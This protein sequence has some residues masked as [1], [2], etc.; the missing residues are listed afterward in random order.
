MSDV[1][2]SIESAYVLY[3]ENHKKVLTAFLLLFFL[4]LIV[5]ALSP[6]PLLSTASLF[7]SLGVECTPSYGDTMSSFES[8]LTCALMQHLPADALV[9]WVMALVTTIVVLCVIKPLEEIISKKKISAWRTHLK[10][11]Q[12]NTIRLV[13]LQTALTAVNIIPAIVLSAFII[14]D[15]AHT[16]HIID[17]G[18]NL[19]Q[20]ASAFLSTYARI[21][22]T[23]ALSILLGFVLLLINI[24]LALS[25]TFVRVELVLT[26]KGL[27]D[28]I[29]KSINLS[30]KNP[31]SVILF[32]ILW[33][34]TDFILWLLAVILCCTTFFI[35]PAFSLLLILPIR[36]LSEIILWK[37]LNSYLK[38]A[39]TEIPKMN[40]LIY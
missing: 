34:I 32:H 20:P 8:N 23:S 22:F 24:I 27:V 7:S 4:S 14:Q 19:M 40:P 15:T 21:M 11:Q 9:T 26:D 1:L 10:A 31:W 25:L 5:K 17:N 29:K 3:K 16:S 35:V 6:I 18:R 37:K 33:L 12:L 39:K 13:V 30:I 2:D 36:L 38:E 28:A